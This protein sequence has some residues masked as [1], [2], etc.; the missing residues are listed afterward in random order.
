MCQCHLAKRWPVPTTTKGFLP[1][2]GNGKRVQRYVEEWAIALREMVALEPRFLLPA[3]GEEIVDDPGRI[4]EV[5]SAHA[6]ALEHIVT[7]YARR[8]ERAPT[9]GRH[10]RLCGVCPPNLSIT[11]TL[12][13]QYVSPSDISRMVMKQYLRL[14]GRHPV[15][16]GA[17]AV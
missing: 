4:A 15:T 14:V 6:E 9:P 7:H 3:H 17:S 8:S 13:E 2:A 10:R 1:N 5:F 11:T 12:R 16:L